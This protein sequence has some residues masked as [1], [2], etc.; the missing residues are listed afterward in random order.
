MGSY[1]LLALF[2]LVLR[3]YFSRFLEFLDTTFSVD[4]CCLNLVVNAHS[5]H[6]RKVFAHVV[7]LVYA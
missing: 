1:T 4:I 6:K 3:V 2:G 5:V 7:A